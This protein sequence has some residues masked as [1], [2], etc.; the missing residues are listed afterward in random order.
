MADDLVTKL[1]V[2]NPDG[3]TP[4]VLLAFLSSIKGEAGGAHGGHGGVCPSDVQ[5]SLHWGSVGV[6]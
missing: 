3:V 5:Q 6:Q 2:Q 1:H 4:S